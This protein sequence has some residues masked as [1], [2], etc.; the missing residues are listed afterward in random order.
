[1]NPQPAF[2]AE[3]ARQRALSEKLLLAAL[4][5]RDVTSEALHAGRRASFLASASR[6]LAMSLDDVATRDA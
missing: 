4:R 6:E 2:V 5:E 3:M 1:M